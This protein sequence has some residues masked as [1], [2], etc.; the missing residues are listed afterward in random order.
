MFV[1]RSE[2]KVPEIDLFKIEI[3]E[4]N[5]DRK[6]FLVVSQHSVLLTARTMK[7]VTQNSPK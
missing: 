5:G 2:K 6:Y 3:R 4:N 7:Y 1:H